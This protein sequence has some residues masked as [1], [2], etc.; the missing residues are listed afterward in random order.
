MNDLYAIKSAAMALPSPLRGAAKHL[1]N[2]IVQLLKRHDHA[3]RIG[4]FFLERPLGHGGFAPVWLARE[5]YGNTTLRLA[6]VKI[7]SLEG[8][9]SGAVRERILDEARSLC[10]VEHPNVVRFY[11]LAIDEVARVMGLAMEHLAGVPLHARL[12]IEA[13]LSVASTLA[14][15]AGLVAALGAV[16]RVGIVHGDV[17]PANILEVAGTPRLIDF[18]IA[19][20]SDAKI[21]DDG[22]PDTPCGDETPR[23]YGRAAGTPGY[24]D[25]YSARTGARASM[26][27]DLYA[28]GAV[29]FECLT[30]CV[31]A[32]AR[33]ALDPKVINGHVL[34]PDVRE[35]RPDVPAAL[36]EL[37]AALLE[38]ERASRPPSA[39]HVAARIA[40]IRRNLAGGPESLPS[41]ETGPFR[42]LARFE[43][44]DR[45]LFFGRE[46]EIAAALA[47][48]QGRGFVALVGPSGSGKSSLVRAGILPAFLEA[49]AA[50]FPKAWDYAFVD[51]GADAG[52]ALDAALKSVMPGA[53]GLRGEA[54]AEALRQH[55]DATRRGILLVV[56]P[57][58]ALA[59]P[60]P[61][62]E[63]VA[64]SL[65]CIGTR[66]ILGLRVVAAARRDMLDPLL[67]LPVLGQALARGLVLIEPLSAATQRD[68]VEQALAAY[69]Y[70]F[71]DE[72]LGEEVFAGLDATVGAMPLAEFALLELWKR[73]DRANRLLTRAALRALGGVAGALERHA[74]ATLASLPRRSQQAAREVLLALTTAEGTRAIRSMEELE[75]VAGPE[76]HSVHSL[77]EA[78]LAARLLSPAGETGAC[79]TL[80]HETLL[81]Q[82]SRLR[83]WVEQARDDR[84]L[85][86]EI[87]RDAAR[88]QS[89]PD[90]APSW[91]GRRLV[92]AEELMRR[93]GAR[94]SKQ[95]E[96]F[97]R[98]SRRAERVGRI[99]AVLVA[100]VVALALAGMGA[101]SVSALRAERAAAERDRVAAEKERATAEKTLLDQQVSAL[102]NRFP[103]AFA[104]MLNAASKP[105]LATGERVELDS[106]G[107]HLELLPQPT[108]PVVLQVEGRPLL[109]LREAGRVGQAQRL[110][111]TMVV[112]SEHGL[113]VWGASTNALEE[114]LYCETD[115][116]GA[117]GAWE[118]EGAQPRVRGES[119]AFEDEAGQTRLWLSAPVA[120][121]GQ[122]RRVSTRLA[123]E[124]ARVTLTVEAHG[125]VVARTVWTT[126]APL[127]TPRSGHTAT[128]LNDG[129]VLV[130]GGTRQPMHEGYD[131]DSDLPAGAR[132]KGNRYLRSAEIYD[133]RTGLWSKTGSLHKARVHASAT[134]LLDG[135]VL[136]VGGQ[137][138]DLYSLA[139]AEIFDPAAGSFSEAASLATRRYLH[140]V[141]RLMDGRVLVSGGLDSSKMLASVEIYDPK[142]NHWTQGHP[143]RLARFAHTE[144]TLADGTVLVVAGASRL[145]PG[146]RGGAERYDPWTDTWS[147]A[148]VLTTARLGHTA[149]RLEDGRV[150]VI[151]GE[152]IAP[153]AAT[154]IYDPR[155]GTWSV[156]AT[157]AEARSQHAAV[158]LGAD[159]VLVLA[160]A[161]GTRATG[162]MEIYDADADRFIPAGM[163][164]DERSRS[165]VVR[166]LDG[167]V[168][169]IG[170]SSGG[171]PMGSVEV[172][173]EVGL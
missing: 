161:V 170:G 46:R 90:A 74:E 134:L 81:L 33:G 117:L 135:R 6:A 86:E 83:G 20:A 114:V 136:I 103:L 18:G 169:V 71:E 35:L 110:G 75:T 73:R 112:W 16:H 82:W 64:I 3:R 40:T 159:R 66:A 63:D 43:D 154:E 7:F 106:G 156:G 102:R 133:P 87:E 59:V 25:P 120:Y 50:G 1:P 67:A 99:M 163:L 105:P 47:G 142:T 72:E 19:A 49:A 125:E 95:A 54:L 132:E 15:G 127:G 37:V 146:I 52:A 77:I 165:A 118:I 27:S 96:A 109:R 5:R 92:F 97:L 78:L 57:L 44:G 173:G 144:T 168:L 107:I 104:S 69:G 13:P 17:K 65:G 85:G 128:R 51:L 55:V 141:D 70:H 2:A 93:R 88:W 172:F 58:E 155:V 10:A 137:G 4:P 166:L 151:G 21:Q 30:G 80:A 121:D 28:C 131:A 24:V 23:L 124:G 56:D 152:S 171:V 158:S 148:G 143:L 68:G 8:A 48:L 98:A 139:S 38:P 12:G 22:T 62:R 39:D 31:P 94:L 122:A 100:V 111:Q 42:G 129:R 140:A 157:L 26:A 41:E 167:S 91:R 76:A 60:S 45:N 160:G 79:V 53:V 119:V 108:E 123:V 164:R 147:D 149:T 29:L 34:P 153:V 9:N 130:V 145:A 115:A 101:S 32:A 113:L 84:R 116:E 150:A 14:L 36:A 138:N 89:E 61:G 11:A 162:R 126:V